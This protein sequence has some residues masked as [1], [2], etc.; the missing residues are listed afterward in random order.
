MSTK[1]SMFAR[2]AAILVLCA[3]FA[4]F[5]ASAPQAAQKAY[6]PVAS[7][8]AKISV[9]QDVTYTG[10]VAELNNEYFLQLPGSEKYYKLENIH[11]YDMLGADVTVKGVVEL[12]NQ[13][14]AV[15]AVREYQ[16][17]GGNQPAAAP[18]KL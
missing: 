1:Q 8:A 14:E 17:V 11:D 9:G 16:I 4:A 2:F 15:I 10:T 3:V 12:K 6:A 7:T 5:I 18:V 13:S